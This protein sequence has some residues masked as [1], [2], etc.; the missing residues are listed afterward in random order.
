[1]TK[2]VESRKFRTPMGVAR[3]VRLAVPD[4]TYEKRGKYQVTLR[5][6]DE[7]IDPLIEEWKQLLDE[8]KEACVPPRKLNRP[9][10]VPLAAMPWTRP[11]INVEG[12]G[13]DAIETPVPGFTDVR[14]GMKA[15]YDDQE[16]NIIYQ[17]PQI[18]DRYGQTID[19]RE[20][21][22]S[23]GSVMS[24]AGWAR[25]F[26]K[27]DQV[28]YGISVKMKMIQVKEIREQDLTEVF[29]F[30][31]EDKPAAMVASEADDGSDDDSFVS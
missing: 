17:K 21:N 22:I 25:C 5:F 10:G 28:G 19:P 14:F 31:I 12:R 20:T 24:V 15:S 29:G 1:M 7:D 8:S 13:D 30:E 3:W 16:G 2:K 4:R 11:A 6:P 18:I 9:N 26:Y 27:S 23:S